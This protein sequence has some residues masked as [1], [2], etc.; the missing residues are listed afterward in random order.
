DEP[1]VVAVR[2]AALNTVLTEPQQWQDLAIFNF[3]PEQIHRLSV[4]TDRE[5]TVARGPKNQ[6]SVA[7]ESVSINQA[8]LQSVLNTLSALHAVRWLGANPPH[9]FDKPQA[10]ITF[11]T[12]PDD[13]GVHKLT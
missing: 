13:K 5:V 8:N 10:I 6:W 11:T 3:K 1:F 4:M 2:Q 12:S 7:K 9:A